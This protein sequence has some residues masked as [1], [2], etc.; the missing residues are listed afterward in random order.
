MKK[1]GIYILILILVMLC[2]LNINSSAF[3]TN[4]YFISNKNNQSLLSTFDYVI[5][6]D[7]SMQDKLSN[8]KSWK[9]SLG[10]SV[11]VETISFI[12]DNYHGVDLAEQIRNCLIENYLDWNIRYVLFVGSRNTIPMRICIPFSEFSDDQFLQCPSDYYYAD[13]TGDWDSD[14]D[15]FFGEY[16]EDD[17]D[18]YPEVI[19]GRIPCDD[20]NEIENILQ[21]II[22]YESDNSD[23]KKN[24]LL[25]GAVIFYKNMEASGYT[26]ERSDGATLMEECR[27]DIFEPNGYSCTRMY[28]EEGLRP[29]IYEYDIPLAKENVLIEWTKN[30]GIVDMLGHASNTKITRLVWTE[31]DGDNIPEYPGELDYTTFL[32]IGDSDDLTLEKP[33]IVYTSGCAQFF[34]SYNMGRKFIEDGAAVAFIGTTQGSWYGESLKWDNENDGGTYSLNYYFFDNLMKNKQSCGNSLYSSKIFYYE[35]FWYNGLDKNW[36]FRSYDNMYSLTLYGDPSLGLYERSNIPDKPDQPDGPNSGKIRT[37]YTYKTSSIDTDGDQVRYLF[38]WG[39]GISTMSDYY[40]SG[41]EISVS[42]KWSEQGDFNIRVR[43][44]DITGEFSDWS[45]PHPVSMPKYKLLFN[46]IQK[47]LFNI[48]KQII[49]DYMN[50]ASYCLQYLIVNSDY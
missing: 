40:S 3:I 36:I 42:H 46:Y 38:D 7:D 32:S 8:F 6:T 16:Q 50:I 24:V 31:D 13:L 29:S 34:S 49:R 4:N 47:E 9:E 14:N 30:Y 20:S 28:E 48:L 19:V 10:F 12:S 1:R 41:E 22:N 5:I 44:Q 15:G 2:L 21:R 39:D 27:L 33:P 17:M 18:F 37:E 11:K 25:A 35:N 45:D 43:C 26:W 23:W